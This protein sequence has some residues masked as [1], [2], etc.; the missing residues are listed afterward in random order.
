MDLQEEVQTEKLMKA[1]LIEEKLDLQE[2]AVRLKNENADL[3]NL[4]HDLLEEV[5]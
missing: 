4:N 3:H 1:N 2:E 5:Q